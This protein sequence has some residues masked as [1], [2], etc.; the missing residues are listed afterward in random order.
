MFSA[1][2]GADKNKGDT[3]NQHNIRNSRTTLTLAQPIV[4]SAVVEGVWR[5]M[6]G[7]CMSGLCFFLLVLSGAAHCMQTM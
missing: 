4:C 2:A 7:F 1:M 3:A 6:S 5:G